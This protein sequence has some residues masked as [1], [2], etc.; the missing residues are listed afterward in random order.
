MPTHSPLSKGVVRIRLPS[1]ISKL[2]ESVSSNS[3]RLDFRVF[4]MQFILTSPNRVG[5][6]SESFLFQ[7]FDLAAKSLTV[8]KEV[9]DLLRLKLDH[10]HHFT[11]PRLDKASDCSL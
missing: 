5:C 9:L 11:D 3:P 1:A 6:S 4:F 10:Q 2:S 7:V 8:S